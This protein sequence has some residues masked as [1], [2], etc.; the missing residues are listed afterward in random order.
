[1][2]RSTL[3]GVDTKMVAPSLFGFGGGSSLTF[4][5]QG[6]QVL[7]ADLVQAKAVKQ[8]LTLLGY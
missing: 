1:M 3:T 7:H 8:V 6:G 2:L 5:G 4:H